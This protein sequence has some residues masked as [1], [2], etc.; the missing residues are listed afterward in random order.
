MSSVQGERTRRLHLIIKGRVQGVN[1]RYR[2]RQ[3]ARE[4]GVS[5]WIRNTPEGSVEAIV[6][7]D[8]AQVERFVQWAHRGPP[9]ASVDEVVVD[10][11]P[12]ERHESGFHIVA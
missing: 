10:E 9:S 3:R 1:F 6:E 5:G 2:A 8:H 11:Q 12:P 7:G 4:L